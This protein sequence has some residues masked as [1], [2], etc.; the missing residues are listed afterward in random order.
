MKSYDKLY[1]FTYSFYSVN[2]WRQTDDF[3]FSFSSSA[4]EASDWAVTKAH[5]WR[6]PERRIKMLL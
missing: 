4:F 2:E 6:D 1:N 5:V 3:S